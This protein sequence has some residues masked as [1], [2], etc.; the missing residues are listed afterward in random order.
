MKKVRI[1]LFILLIAFAINITAVINPLHIEWLDQNYR[2]LQ[3]LAGSVYFI[4]QIIIIA[5]A[6]PLHRKIIV[7]LISGFSCG[8]SATIL[9]ATL[10]TLHIS[11]LAWL[12]QGL[13]LPFCA[14]TLYLLTKCMLCVIPKRS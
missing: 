6:L 4:S 12:A 5:S 3:L 1:Q 7:A 8:I 10:N 9:D 11:N 2:R 13:C 14:A